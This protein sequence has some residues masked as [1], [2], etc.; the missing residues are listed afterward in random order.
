MSRSVY[1]FGNGSAD[2]TRDMKT[3]LGGKGA[4]LAEMTNLGVPVPPGFTIAAHRCVSYLADGLVDDALRTEV[5]CAL[6]RL[7]E[8]SGK[9]FGDASTPHHAF[10]ATRP[11]V[12]SELF[13]A[14]RH[15]HITPRWDIA[16]FDGHTVHST[17]GTQAD[18]D[19]S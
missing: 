11:T 2:G 4:N 6:T 12:N 15:G 18:C 14:L 16:R 13:C 5:A 10:G 17:D 9:R 1:F 7:E 19:G 3:M 8:V